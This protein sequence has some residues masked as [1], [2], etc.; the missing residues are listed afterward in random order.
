LHYMPTFRIPGVL[1]RFC[2][3]YLV[4]AL[5]EFF[6]TKPGEHNED[7][8]YA[9]IRDIVNYWM[10]WLIV[11][12]LV[13]LQLILT[14][15][16]HV[17]GC[18][19]GYLG[20]GGHL[21][22]QNNQT[23]QNC[24]GGA[25]GYIDRWILGVQH[26]YT[27][28]T[29]KDVYQTTMNYDPEGILGSC[30]SVF[31]CFLGLQAGKILFTYKTKSGKIKRWIL[32]AIVTGG[33]A[34]ILCKCSKE[35]GWI[36]INKNLWSI[37]FVLCLSS[38]AFILFTF[39]YVTVDVL[40]IWSGAPFYYPGMNS[41]LVYVG[42]LLLGDCFPFIWDTGESHTARLTVHLCGTTWWILIAMYLHYLGFYV[43]I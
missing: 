34:A 18:P 27:D 6:F 37:S 16:L 28:P 25:A 4:V 38:M 41:I 23:L 43:K 35:D 8:W 9:P 19:T 13:A 33:I 30:M 5:M 10:E 40:N 15:I 31:M 14:F 29:C 36:P 17:P 42:H 2:I 21:L 12:S 39:C 22:T 7:K 32:W 20:P 24:T 26:L 1:Q 3:T 11:L